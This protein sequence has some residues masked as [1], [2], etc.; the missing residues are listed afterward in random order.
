MHNITV[1]YLDDYT[2]EH[3]A[4]MK[5]IINNLKG[6]EVVQDTENATSIKVTDEALTAIDRLA[7][8]D[9]LYWE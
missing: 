1:F 6:V 3:N 7:I 5:Y 2:K 8:A 9:C 4:A